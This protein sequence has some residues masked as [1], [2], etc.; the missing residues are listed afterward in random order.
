MR[1]RMIEGQVALVTGASSGVGWQTA[2]KL[3]EEGMRLCLSARREEPLEQLRDELRARGVDV[4]ISPGDVTSDEDVERV[5]A[6]CIRHHGRLDVLVNVPS[7]QLF[8]RFEDYAWPEITRIMDVNFFGYLR[9]TRA[10]LP[11]FH[12]Q[13][14]GHVINVLS[15][16]AEMGF[17]LFSIYAAS[18]H[19]LMGWADSLRL[20]LRGSGIDVSNI[21]L[22]TIATPFYDVAPTRL[23]HE[24]RPPPPVYSPEAAARAVARCAHRPRARHVPSLLQGKLALGARRWAGPLVDVVLAQLGPRMVTSPKPVDRPEGNLFLPREERFGAHGTARATP[25]WLR[26]GMNAAVLLGVLGASGLLARR[27]LPT[28]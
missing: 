25:F 19:A 24:P 20:E 12:R 18:K 2:V 17:P 22:P 16:F 27:L 13:G 7:V 3:G 1:K 8:S 5:V 11:H 26:Q 9:L 6:D 14:R 28:S 4:I 21:L 10:V 23:G 15:V